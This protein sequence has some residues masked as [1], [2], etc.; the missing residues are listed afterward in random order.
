MLG[1]T[2]CVGADSIDRFLYETRVIPSTIDYVQ[3][4][5]YTVSMNMVI[6]MEKSYNPVRSNKYDCFDTDHNSPLFGS[7]VSRSKIMNVDIF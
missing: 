1:E 6:F 2:N 3:I 7:R 4:G 5:I